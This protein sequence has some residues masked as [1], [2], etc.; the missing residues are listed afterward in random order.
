MTGLP[1]ISLK[2]HPDAQSLAQP[3][4]DACTQSGFFYVTDHGIPESLTS[5]MFSLM[6]QFF[7][8]STQSKAECPFDTKSGLVR[9]LVAIRKLVG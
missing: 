7:A 1:V 6:R 9:L 8:Q 5:S 3:L 4:Y 2:Q